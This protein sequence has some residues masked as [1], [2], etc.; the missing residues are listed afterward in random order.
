MSQ[1]EQIIIKNIRR[2]INQKGM[3]QKAVAEMAG[4]TPQ[5]F[6]HMMNGRKRIAAIYIPKIADA[7]DVSCND[8]FETNQEESA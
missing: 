8:L 7:L 2:I 4:F 1:G 3:K 6:S 5:E